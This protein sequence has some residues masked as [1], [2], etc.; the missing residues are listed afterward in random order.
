MS[1]WLR[2]FGILGLVLL[3][4][5]LIGGIVVGSFTQWL[6]VL[7]LLGGLGLIVTSLV[8]SPNSWGSARSV[9]IG[10]RA[11]LGYFFSVYSLVFLA[12]LVTANWLVKKYDRRWDLTAEG[13]YSLSSQSKKA[14]DSLTKPLRLVSFTDEPQAKSLLDLYAF[15]SSK[16]SVET[17]N[18]RTKPQLAEKYGMSQGNLIYLEYG[19]G[20]DLAASRVNDATEDAVTNALIKLTRGAARKLYYLVGHGE[21]GLEDRGPQGVLGLKMAID[22]EHMSVEALKLA[23]QA[24]VPADAAAVL[25]VGSK[26][27]LFPHE[28]QELKKYADA[29]GSLLILTDPRGAPQISELVQAY[30]VKIGQNVVIDQVVRLF[31]GPALG[32]EPIVQSYGQ[33]P[34]T[35]ELTEQD[36]VVFSMAS[37]VTGEGSTTLVSSGPAS[38][39]ETNLS[40]VLDSDQASAAF[41]AADMRG[42]VS[43]AVA[44]EKGVGVGEQ[45]QSTEDPSFKKKTRV[46]VFGDSDWVQNE[47]LTFGKHRDLI[48]NSL[49]W[50]AGEEG[51]VSIRPRFL[52]PSIEPISRNA[53]LGLLAS[54]LLLP[55][56]ILV[57]GLMVWWNRRTVI[58]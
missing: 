42:P 39:A 55:E 53:I 19:E 54:S 56:L 28:L 20:K 51:G 58:A 33:H 21:P 17:I 36:L 46:V 38:W 41:D 52:K 50:L 14:L 3:T 7:H 10:R 16:V 11:R 43:M 1:R 31:G 30:A 47:R 8:A 23:E 49:G 5:G 9:M 48:L 13:V 35:S 12:L 22:D 37:S 45:N 15:H 40:A 44:Y 18:P 4:F 25:I 27:P 57:F 2:F 29:G 26:Q 32:V 34:I 6:I 24:S